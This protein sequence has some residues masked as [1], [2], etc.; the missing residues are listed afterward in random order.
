M[1]VYKA[2]NLTNGKIYIGCTIKT[3]SHRKIEHKSEANRRRGRYNIPFYNA[4]RKY[5][6]DGFSW[7][8]IWE[9][10]SEHEMWAEEIRVISK[11]NATSPDIGYNISNGGTRG[12]FGI[13]KSPDQIKAMSGPGNPFYGRKHSEYSK[14]LMRKNS[15][16]SEEMKDHLRKINTGKIASQA[17]RKKMS[18]SQKRRYKMSPVT[19]ETR[20]KISALNSGRNN[21]AT[22]KW[23]LTTPSN[24]VIILED[25]LVKGLKKYGLTRSRF[26]NYKKYHGH[27]AWPAYVDGYKLEPIDAAY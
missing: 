11:S 9:G 23:I 10:E 4:I 24:D 7:D 3:L 2:T 26:Y 14:N 8:I 27:G 15:I 12:T 20:A 17:T 16:V 22:K 5:G 21:S 6:M 13:K 19:A 18:Q 1:I 25:G